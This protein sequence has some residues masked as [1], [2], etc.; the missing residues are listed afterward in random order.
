MIKRIKFAGSAAVIALFAVTTFSVTSCS[1]GKSGVPKGSAELRVNLEQGDAYNV[2]M[3]ISQTVFT[4]ETMLEKMMESETKLYSSASVSSAQ[5]NV[6]TLET[7]INRVVIDQTAQGME[8]NYDSD[9]GEPEDMIGAMVHQQMAPLMENSMTTKVDMMGKVI[10]QD[11]TGEESE[12]MD[13]GSYLIQFPEEYVSVGSTWTK[14]GVGLMDDANV[15]YTVKEIQSDNVI[16]DVT[17][18]TQQAEE[19]VDL[20]IEI[21]GTITIDRKTGWPVMQDLKVVMS[22][23]A[24]GQ[25]MYMIQNIQ[26][27][28]V[29]Q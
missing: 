17:S 20:N 11:T 5:E 14:D 24:E 29:K 4:D 6:Y 22:G 2:E 23:E 18:N 1:S 26:M 3:A 10:K 9:Q 25:P 28:S 21:K 19:G 8:I 7:K 27:K 13:G 15:T 16:L 12:L